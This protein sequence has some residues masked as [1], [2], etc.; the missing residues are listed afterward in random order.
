[1]K[2]LILI[3]LIISVLL[4]N[5]KHQNISRNDKSF[6]ELKGLYLGMNPPG[7]IPEIFAPRVIST[8]LHEHSSV[9]FSPDG[10]EVFWNS[11]FFSNYKYKFPRLML[12][13]KLINNVWLS[14]EY[15]KFNTNKESGDACFSHDGKKLFFSSE[16]I[17]ENGVP[18]SDI[19]FVHKTAKGWSNAEKIP[20]AVNTM[21][22]ERQGTVTRNLTLYYF[23]IIEGTGNNFGI[24]RSEFIDGKYQKP[25]LLPNH[26]NSKNTDWTP[27]ISP[28][29]D[30]ILWSSDRDGGYGSGDL[31]I[32]FRSKKG[33]W[34]EALNLGPKINN[35]NNERFPRISPDGKYL[36][37]L[38]DQINDD[39]IEDKELSYNEAVKYYNQPGNGWSDIYWVDAKIIEELKKSYYHK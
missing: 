3:V 11:E 28:N 6:I 7:E 29:E 26:I 18:N 2:I 22:M 32:S 38:T 39:L 27:F 9:A 30:Y 12:G 1:M 24:Y 19:W 10:T 8:S 15:M 23:S 16:E 20:G 37:Y 21:K 36:F 4:T 14:P 33:V 25:K 17:S 5:C 13:M 34:S 31:Y 35:N